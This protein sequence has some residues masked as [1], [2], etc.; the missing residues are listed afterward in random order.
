MDDEDGMQ[1]TGVY[2][3]DE[4]FVNFRG[5][6]E[7]VIGPYSLS[8]FPWTH[9]G[10]PR[11]LYEGEEQPDLPTN[12]PYNAKVIANS[13]STVNMRSGPSKSNSVIMK[14]NLGE[15]VQVNGIEEGWAQITYNG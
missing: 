12:F 11:G 15:T 14:I 3:G 8:S 13:G 10:I 1:H 2:L 9:Y 4:T 6:R 7:G 5:S